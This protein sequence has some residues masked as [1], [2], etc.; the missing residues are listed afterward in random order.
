MKSNLTYRQP[1]ELALEHSLNF[2]ENLDYESVSATTTLNEL[3][4][5]LHKELSDDGIEPARIIDEL[6]KDVNGGLIGSAG[7]RFFGWVIGG[8]LPA[9][10]AADWLTS[11]WDQNSVLYVTS[12]AQSVIEEVCGEWLKDILKIPK[13][14]SFA[15]VTGCQL[16]HVTCLASARNALLKKSQWDVESKGLNGAPKIHVL[17]TDERHGTIDRALRLLGFG[18]EC[19]IELPEDSEGRMQTDLLIDTLNKIKGE[20]A[21]VLLKAGDLNI[22]AYDK[23]EEIIPAAHSFNAWVHVDGAFGLWV[24]A[25]NNLSHLLKGVELADSWAAD[26]HKWLNVPFDCGYA[27]VSDSKSHKAAMTHKASYITLADNARDQIDWTPEWSRRGRGVATYAAIRQLGRRGI[28][29][30]VERCCMYVSELVSLIGKL[31]GAEIIWKPQINQGLVRFLD[32][33]PNATESEHD[34][35]TDEVIAEILKNGKAFFGG[36][37][38]RGIRCMRISVCNWQ[39]NESH[40]ETAHLAVKEALEKCK[41]RK[42]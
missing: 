35:F 27:F 13:T 23:F 29:E 32:P 1:L 37:T 25:N 39:T 19:I 17:T 24:A 41:A 28:A 16:A 7:G 40:I 6:V 10:L 34:R 33:S 31:D 11:A 8:S 12:P 14:A 4:Q 2:I 26:G 9:A 22:G 42:K 38:W 18:T 20:P 21:I 36:T 30:L 15:L 3:R 5:R